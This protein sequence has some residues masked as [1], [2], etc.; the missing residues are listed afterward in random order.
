MSKR[1]WVLKVTFDMSTEG[2]NSFW[3]AHSLIVKESGLDGAE[4]W[5]VEYK[6]DAPNGWPMIEVTFQSTEVAKLY[7][8]TYLGLDSVLDD[9]V[10]EYLSTSEYVPA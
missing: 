3:E 9:E 8:A 7:T 4:I 6:G 5:N 1:H 10:D 2:C